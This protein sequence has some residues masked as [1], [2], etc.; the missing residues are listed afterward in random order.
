MAIQGYLAGYYYIIPVIAGVV[1]IGVFRIR[2]MVLDFHRTKRGLQ[3][4]FTCHGKERWG[5]PL[6]VME[7]RRNAIRHLIAQHETL[8]NDVWQI[9]NR[10][11]NLS[12]MEKEEQNR[13]SELIQSAM[14]LRAAGDLE[15]LQFLDF[16]ISRS[17]VKIE[18]LRKRILEKDTVVLSMEKVKQQVNACLKAYIRGNNPRLPA[19]KNIR[20]CFLI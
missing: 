9:K 1:L 5:P 2:H 8:E 7:W 16:Q 17:K 4:F 11:N 18:D 15:K 10:R 12:E 13:L 20:D 3:Q 19:K 6:R 14:N